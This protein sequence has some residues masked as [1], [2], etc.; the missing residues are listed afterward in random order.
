MA[1][2]KIS[3]GGQSNLSSVDIK[4]GWAYFTPDTKNFFID[5]N[6]NINGQTFNKRIQIN[7][8]VRKETITLSKTAWSN[9]KLTYTLAQSIPTDEYYIQLEPAIAD[10]ASIENSYAITS[11]LSRANLSYKLISDGTKLEITC[12]GTVPTS[13]IDLIMLIIP[14]EI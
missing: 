8:K 9:K 12:N 7:E 6:S 1:L 5:V 11:L 3:R 10:S 14:Q 13:N 2:F 4:D